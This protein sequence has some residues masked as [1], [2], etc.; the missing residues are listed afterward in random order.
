MPLLC[1]I[2]GAGALMGIS[3]QIMDLFHDRSGEGDLG[4]LKGVRVVGDGDDE[5][6]A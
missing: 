5:G 3:S 4:G 2:E 1:R 6:L